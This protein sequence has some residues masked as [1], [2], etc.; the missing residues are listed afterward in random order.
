[1]TKVHNPKPKKTSKQAKEPETISLVQSPDGSYRDKPILGRPTSVTPDWQELICEEIANGKSLYEICEEYKNKDIPDYRSIMRLLRKDEYFRQ[2]YTRAREEQQEAL[3]EQTITIAKGF[4][5]YANMDVQE[6][7]LLIDTVKWSAGKLRP[8]V[9]GDRINLDV[10]QTTNVKV[11]LEQKLDLD[12]LDDETLAQLQ[13]SLGQLQI[14][15]KKQD[16]A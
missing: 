7:R 8:K 10:E 5:T 2:Q 12:A 4:G 13:L 15:Q 3:A 6:R 1:M 16:D 14:A 11:Q 9:Y